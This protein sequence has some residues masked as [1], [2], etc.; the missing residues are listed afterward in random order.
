MSL[1]RLLRVALALLLTAMLAPRFA[2]A[3]QPVDRIVAVVNDEI[4][5]QSDLRTRV[6]AATATLKR[7]GTALPSADQ[8]ERQVLDRMIYDKLQ[9]QEAAN[10]NVKVDDATLQR[11][12]Q[13]IAENNRMNINQLREAVEK[14]E[15]VPW[16]RFREDIRNEIILSRLR[17]RDVDSKVVVTDAEV[18]AFLASPEAAAGSREVQIQHILLRAPEGATPEQWAALRK[19]ADEVQRQIRQGDDFAKL[20][21]TYS[22]A[23]DAMQGGILDWRPIERLPAIYGEAVSRMK[24]GQVSDTMQSSVGLHIVR[25]VNE[26]ATTEQ[27]QQI[28]QTHA[29]HILI[30]TSDAASDSDVRQRLIALRERIV[31]GVDFA[32]MARTNSVDGTAA[33]GGDLGW[34]SP[35]DTV[36]E[37]ERAMNALKVGE[38]SQPVQSPFG[39][40]LIQVLERRTVDVTDDRRRAQ[41]RDALHDRKADEAFED[42]LRQLRDQA[43]VDVRLDQNR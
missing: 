29:R 30:R 38:V 8:L 4:I 40:H 37:F 42:W 10:T 11:A 43:Y 33:K 39:W 28:E 2:Q 19:R 5:T 18:D 12:L 41:A 22:D 1:N 14:S 25:F 7:Q 23:Q 31:N 17:E 35:G 20:A 24:P 16:D 9:L 3:Q 36:P 13:T 6:T 34:V 26:R 15:G 32:E 27:K 21:A